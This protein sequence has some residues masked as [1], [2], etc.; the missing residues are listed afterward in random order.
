MVFQ[1][2]KSFGF[3]KITALLILAAFL[4]SSG[5]C[6]KK[7]D[8]NTDAATMSWIANLTVGLGFTD[9][10]NGL[11]QDIN[12]NLVWM[13]C[14]YGQVWN[15]AFN[16]C[17][18][19]GGFTTYGAKSLAFCEAVLDHSITECTTEDAVNPIAISG[20]AFN[21][22]A[23]ETTGGLA[24]RL[25]T[26]EE[27]NAFATVIATKTMLD[28]VFPQTPDDKFFWTSTAKAE[29]ED[30]EESYGVSFAAQTF[31]QTDL[32]HKANANL[33]VRCISP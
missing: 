25:P 21:A 22:C 24:W 28:Y 31:G 30:G 11:I 10:G 15:A 7:D 29:S 27:M 13:K 16:D 3:M 14:S 26:R 5:A 33:Y 20:P 18:G 32:F 4:L 19:I 12:T 8:D 6:K 1:K 23:Y 17:A 9:L 2:M